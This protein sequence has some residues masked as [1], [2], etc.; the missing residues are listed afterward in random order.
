MEMKQFDNAPVTFEQLN[1]I[2]SAMVETLIEFYHPRISYS[3]E[4][5][6]YYIDLKKK[7]YCEVK[8]NF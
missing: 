3:E 1:K 6:K 5:I 4:K 8:R 2:K 7:K